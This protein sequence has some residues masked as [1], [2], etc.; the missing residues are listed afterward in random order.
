MGGNIHFALKMGFHYC[1]RYV[2]QVENENDGN[3]VDEWDYEEGPAEI[4]WQGNE[5]IL[6]KKGVKI[7][8]KTT[9]QESRKVCNMNLELCLD[10]L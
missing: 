10:I 6:K 1:L 7:P 9:D 5:I 4:I 3:E 2:W 8:K